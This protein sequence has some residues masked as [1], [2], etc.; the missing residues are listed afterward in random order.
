MESFQSKSPPSNSVETPIDAHVESEKLHLDWTRSEL[1]KQRVAMKILHK[2]WKCRTVHHDLI[3]P[4]R[5]YIYCDRQS[6]E[7]SRFSNTRRFPTDTNSIPWRLLS[8]SGIIV[9]SFQRKY[10]TEKHFNSQHVSILNSRLSR[11]SSPLQQEAEMVS[12]KGCNEGAN[13][14]HSDLKGRNSVSDGKSLVINDI[15]QSCTALPNV[16]IK[17]DAIKG[18]L[19]EDLLAPFHQPR[20]VRA[21]ISVNFL[22]TFESNLERTIKL[23]QPNVDTLEPW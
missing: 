10:E 1:F 6:A 9:P 20:G 12:L 11:N 2:S 15:A 5:S 22:R 17:T 16:R 19:P 14:T 13:H 4:H 23:C 21:N 18:T 8:S 7:N 3:T